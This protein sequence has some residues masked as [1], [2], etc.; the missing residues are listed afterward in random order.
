[1]SNLP[2]YPRALLYVADYEGGIRIYQ[3]PTVPEEN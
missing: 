1:M 2:G 3:H